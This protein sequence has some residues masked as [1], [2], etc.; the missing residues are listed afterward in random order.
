MQSL[1]LFSRLF[2]LMLLFLLPP[3]AAQDTNTVELTET[4]IAENGQA[5]F[6]YPTGWLLDAPEVDNGRLLDGTFASNQ[7]ALDKQYSAPGSDSE[8]R[9]LP[10]E[11]LM[12]IIVGSITDLAGD[13]PGISETATAPELLQ[14]LV[15]SSEV[16]DYISFT[17]EVEATSVNDRRAGQVRFKLENGNEGWI[18]FV[19]YRSDRMAGLAVFAAQGELEQWLPTARTVVASIRLNTSELAQTVTT[20][21]GKTTVHYPTDWVVGENVTSGVTL[22]TNE[23]AL[24]RAL[25]SDTFLSGEATLYIEARSEGFAGLDVEANASPYKVLQA[26]IKINNQA[27][28]GSPVVTHVGDKIA[29]RVSYNVEGAEGMTWMVR[30]QP[31]V[32][33]VVGLVTAPDEQENWILTALAIAESVV[34]NP[35][36]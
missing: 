1:R 8:G 10:G 21:D 27:S 11:V 33:M 13:F 20:G 29:A 9:L 4:Y 22:A 32:M 36:S 24:S 14:A 25:N 15:S 30:Y 23:T 7:A 28:F 12:Q 2:L 19:E 16:P 6:S 34:Y 17:S 31:G 5:L 26:L 18:I 35:A 3:V